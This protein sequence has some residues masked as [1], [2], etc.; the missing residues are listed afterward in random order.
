KIDS[1][2]AAP[3]SGGTSP[4]GDD[5]TRALLALGYN[6][7]EADRAVRAIIEAQGASDVSSVVR[8]ALA[9]LTAK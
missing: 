7:S 8:A 2:G 5:A 4:L 1:V 3:S 9:R 6:Q